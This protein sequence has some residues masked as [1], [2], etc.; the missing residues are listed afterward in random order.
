MK[1]RKTLASALSAAFLLGLAAQAGAASTGNP[2]SAPA[3][4]GE[5]VQMAEM[6]NGKCGAGKCGASM[7]MKQADKPMKDGKCGTMKKSEGMKGG[8]CGTGKCGGNM[9]K[10]A[11][12]M[13]MKDGKCGSGMNMKK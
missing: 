2:F 10:P 1:T 3:A 7:N 11:K 12:P 9:K 4:T 8:K 5:S 13:N 6:K